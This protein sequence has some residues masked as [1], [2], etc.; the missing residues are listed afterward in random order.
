MTE[1]ELKSAIVQLRVQPSLKKAAEFAAAAERRSLTTLVEVALIEWL[2]N[3]GYWPPA[4]K[5]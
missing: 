5:R 2:R 1:T 4:T 3:H